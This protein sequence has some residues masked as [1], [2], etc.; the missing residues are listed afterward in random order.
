MLN[1]RQV[2]AFRVAVQLGSATA[3]AD[4][5]Y[6]T[7]PAVSRLIADLERQVGFALFERRQRGLFPTRDGRLLYEEVERS[8]R[9]MDLIA[10]AAEAIRRHRLGRVRVIA[11]PAYADGF[12]SRVIGG[13][14]SERPG[15]VIELESAPKKE[16]VAR[17][18]S[19]QFD[20]GVATAPIADS[21]LAQHPIAEQQAVCV[22]P[23]EHAL[24]AK[25]K[26]RV[27][28]LAAQ[29]FIALSLGSPFRAAVEQMFDAAGLRP[30]IVAEVRTQR[31]VC[32]MVVAGAGIAVIDPTVAR[33]YSPEPLVTLAIEPPQDWTVVALTPQR[34]TPSQAT[35]ALLEALVAAL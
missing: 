17:V 27:A 4:A 26:V 14:L 20:L 35:S 9:G 24:S 8:F 29:P 23:A 15:V 16:T 25:R 5:L 18:L 28:D 32:N 31:A 11:M 33:D 12:V 22:C 7:Q 10:E 19:E 30:R 6:I 13:F 34:T 3:A 2:E 21:G 1:H